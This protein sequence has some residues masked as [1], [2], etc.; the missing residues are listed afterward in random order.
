MFS[1]MPGIQAATLLVALILVGCSSGEADE[2]GSSAPPP[3]EVGQCHN[4]PD[5][6]LDF[7]DLFDDS[8]V[9]DC[10][11]THT[12]QT[13]EV[14]E[15]DEEPTLELLQQLAK[16][17]ETQAVA[18]YVDSPGR[19][20]YNLAWPIVFGPTPEQ[21]EAGQSWVRC[22]T[23][24]QAET[25]MVGGCCKPL[26][27]VTGSLEGAMGKDI[28]RFQQCIGQVPDLDT[29]QPLVS[30]NE[31]HRGELLLTF[32]ELF[33]S[34]YPPAAKLEKE[35]QSQCTKLVAGR[36]D[37]DSLVLTPTWQDE[38]SWQGGTIVGAC[39]IHRKTGML[40]GA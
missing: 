39:W 4:T 23:G 5:S 28:A 32:I 8:P 36:D 25:R 35:G 34:E 38:E 31:P 10:S 30:C 21:Q 12:L 29:S 14:I 33:A 11:Q 13:L 6:N 7:E 1:S 40:P 22:D 15:I 19:G 3:A 2:S 27:P 24:F 37:A 9:V 16:Y 20:A 18:E 26:V 17:C